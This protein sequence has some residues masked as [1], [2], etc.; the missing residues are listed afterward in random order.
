MFTYCEKDAHRM[1]PPARAHL[2]L[3]P[4][5]A[6]KDEDLK[7]LAPFSGSL[8][9]END[10][11]E[12]EIHPELERLP[13]LTLRGTFL[14][15]YKIL[16]SICNKIGWD[17][18]LRHRS[19]VFVMEEEY[20]IHRALVEEGEKGD[21]DDDEE[22]DELPKAPPLP[23]SGTRYS[24]DSNQSED[25]DKIIMERGSSANA[26][27]PSSISP[28]RARKSKNK[29]LSID[30]LMQK[31]NETEIKSSPTANESVNSEQKRAPVY[32]SNLESTSK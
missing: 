29:I 26:E 28:D 21:E 9:D 20:R 13:S 32:L 10:P 11:R 19:L 30:N 8:Y 2:P 27:R 7:K 25:L 18:L 14:K 4:E 3:K 24:N 17:E 15:A 12:N 16:N 1:P 31:V 22:L 23:P 6:P 5:P